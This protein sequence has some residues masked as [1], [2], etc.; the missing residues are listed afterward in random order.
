MAYA[1]ALLAADDRHGR[2]LRQV[3]AEGRTLARLV[4]QVGPGKRR[5]GEAHVAEEVAKARISLLGRIAGI[6]LQRLVGHVAEGLADVLLIV[7]YLHFSCE[8][9][10]L[11]GVGH[12]DDGHVVVLAT[13]IVAVEVVGDHIAI[14]AG[15]EAAETDIAAAERIGGELSHLLQRLLLQMALEL[16]SVLLGTLL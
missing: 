9:S 13:L 11:V 4:L 6:E 3:S 10:P 12:D 8:H 5:P 2:R 7:G 15:P 14:D 16:Q 1:V